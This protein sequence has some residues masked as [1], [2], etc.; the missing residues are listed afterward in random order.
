MAAWSRWEHRTVRREAAGWSRRRHPSWHS[1]RGITKGTRI[2][3]KNVSPAPACPS[4]ASH[5]PCRDRQWVRGLDAVTGPCRMLELESRLGCV[6][7]GAAATGAQGSASWDAEIHQTPSLNFQST[8]Y[9]EGHFQ[10][11]PRS[12]FCRR[13]VPSPPTGTATIREVAA[14]RLQQP[15]KAVAAFRT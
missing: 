5:L 3:M 11:P 10:R 15:S 4:A 9:F 2:S 7:A 12:C 1:R 14:A 13:K 8:S 6:Q